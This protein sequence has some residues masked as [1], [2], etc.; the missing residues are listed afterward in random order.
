M[1]IL[2]V[3]TNRA[4]YSKIKPKDYDKHFFEI[5]RQLYKA[6]PDGLT[7]TIITEYGR[8]QHDEE[9]IVYKENAIV[10]YHPRQQQYTMAKIISEID[11]HKL[12]TAKSTFGGMKLMMKQAGDVWKQLKVMLPILAA[13]IILLYAVLQ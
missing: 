6:Y 11:E 7:R 5:R 9:F 13:G 2:I 3:G 10:P 1:K 4:E 8:R 12:M